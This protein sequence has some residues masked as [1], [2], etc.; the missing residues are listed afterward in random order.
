MSGFTEATTPDG[1]KLEVMAGGA[2]GGYP[3]LFHS[4]TPSAAAPYDRLDDM[5]AKAD[6]R[7]VT[8]SRPGYGDSTPRVIDGTGPRITDDVDDSVTVLDHL[9]INEFIT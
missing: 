1:R 2:E 4:G 7:L 6:L 5:L 3:L 9:G 8:Y